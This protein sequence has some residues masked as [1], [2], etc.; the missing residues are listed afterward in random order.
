MTSTRFVLL[1]K[2]FSNS[3]TSESA[4]L[5]W[6]LFDG[7]KTIVRRV[8]MNNH[9]Y[10]SMYIFIQPLYHHQ[11]VRLLNSF[12]TLNGQKST[13]PNYKYYLYSEPVPIKTNCNMWGNIGFR[14][15]DQTVYNARVF[16][17]VCN[18]AEGISQ[19]EQV[20]QNNKMLWCGVFTFFRP[21][22]IELELLLANVFPTAECQGPYIS[23]SEM[24][25]KSSVVSSLEHV[26]IMSSHRFHMIN[27]YVEHMSPLSCVKVVFNAS[28]EITSASMISDTTNVSSDIN[29]STN[30]LISI[31][32]RFLRVAI[33]V[34]S[35]SDLGIKSAHCPADNIAII[36]ILARSDK[37]DTLV[38]FVNT[39]VMTGKLDLSSQGRIPD[40]NQ[41]HIFVKCRNEYE[42]LELYIK[43]YCNNNLFLKAFGQG[44]H[45]VFGRHSVNTINSLILGR[46]F[47]HNMWLDL[48]SCAG[49]NDHVILLN[50]HAMVLDIVGDGEKVKICK[51]NGL[52]F[53]AHELARCFT[54]KLRVPHSDQDLSLPLEKCYQ[55]QLNKVKA[56]QEC[57]N[58]TFVSDLEIYTRLAVASRRAMD[59]TDNIG[60]LRLCLNLC[61]TL[62]VNL[63][64]LNSMSTQMLASKM[65]FV[66][67]L[68]LGVFFCTSPF[69]AGVPPTCIK[70]PPKLELRYLLCSKPFEMDNDSGSRNMFYDSP[71]T[72]EHVQLSRDLPILQNA[73]ASIKDFSG[74][75]GG[76]WYSKIGRFDGQFTSYDFNSFY[77]S[78]V[79]SVS[80]DFAN[81]CIMTSVE[82]RCFA[83]RVVSANSQSPASFDKYF[84]ILD[85]YHPPPRCCLVLFSDIQDCNL[86]STFLVVFPK[87]GQMRA[88]FGQIMAQFLRKTALCSREEKKVYK[89]IVNSSIGCLGNK[90]FQYYS[91]G[92]QVAI[93]ALGQFFMYLTALFLAHSE[94]SFAE[95]WNLVLLHTSADDK[96]LMKVTTDGILWKGSVPAANIE[97]FLKLVLENF[98]AKSH[99]ELKIDFVTDFIF[100][101]S[102]NSVYHMDAAEQRIKGPLLDGVIPP[103]VETIYRFEPLLHRG[104]YAH[105]K[106]ALIYMYDY[107]RTKCSRYP[108][109]IGH[110][111]KKVYDRKVQS[112]PNEGP[113][114]LLNFFNAT[115]PE[116]LWM[117]DPIGNEQVSEGLNSELST[118]RK[119][120]L[121][122]VDSN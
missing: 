57:E 53:G 113:C 92:M 91:L 75:N 60:L 58:R 28:D 13:H 112:Y 114:S 15:F 47:Y 35:S 36:C 119:I 105:L 96:R 65:V 88:S 31:L 43:Y 64:E 61:N 97:N 10:F 21:P 62:K 4:V 73:C 71:K 83:H 54:D 121:E 50:R 23:A 82:L 7:Q 33:S 3:T 117:I 99:L 19:L 40:E 26:Q 90:Y 68:R 63:R 48:K 86:E 56:W 118:L 84:L 80:L 46:I 85:L 59:Q 78:V 29:S 111:Y 69:K 104:D 39:Q 79:A 87:Y 98:N 41:D 17:V 55:H 2:F 110:F 1:D 16:R 34:V 11:M 116:H 12:E 51:T 6:S 109:T 103:V 66:S 24:V 45:Y 8:N 100:S 94:K 32:S 42:L 5:L 108:E 93:H 49:F 74:M 89:N 81:H 22:N 106:I 9:M 72:L 101:H 107:V 77:P 37:R 20:L 30:T 18:L 44:L 25:N 14:V 70:L 52:T 67:F 27:A 38:Y 115:L 122:T 102:K 76:W 120:L 95:I